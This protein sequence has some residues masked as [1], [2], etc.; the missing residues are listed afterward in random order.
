MLPNLPIP[1]ITVE[2]EFQIV[3]FDRVAQNLNR[4]QA[5]S[6]LCQCNRT[7]EIQRS[8]I[9]ALIKAQTS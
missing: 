5:I 4:E 3:A 1:E 9:R 2:Q 7:V 8:L 6:L